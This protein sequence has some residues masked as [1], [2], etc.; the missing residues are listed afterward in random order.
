MPMQV[1]A[2]ATGEM[3]GLGSSFE[4]K[5]VV[6]ARLFSMMNL[7]HRMRDRPTHR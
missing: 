3:T 6:V 1:F 7:V 2:F 4:T 5:P